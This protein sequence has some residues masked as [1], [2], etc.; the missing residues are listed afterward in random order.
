MAWNEKTG[1]KGCCGC[2]INVIVWGAMIIASLL[3][4]L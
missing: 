2:I 3:F 1:S 4:F